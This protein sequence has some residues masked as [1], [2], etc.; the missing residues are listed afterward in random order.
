MT[1]LARQAFAKIF[2]TTPDD[3]DMVGENI[4]FLLILK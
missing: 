1:F 4:Y 3:L 2:N